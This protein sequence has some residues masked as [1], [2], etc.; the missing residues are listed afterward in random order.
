[1]P[2][3]DT[4]SAP[5]HRVPI[6]EEQAVVHKQTMDGDSVTVQT[7]V[8]ET[9]QWAQETL[10]EEDVSVLR[11]PKDQWI[12][13][14]PEIREEEGVII[15]PVV[16]EVLHVEKRLMLVEELHVTRSKK[17]RSIRIPITLRHTVVEV[18]RTEPDSTAG[19]ES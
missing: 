18:T 16:R 7:R 2:D 4:D 10:L 9:T 6:V 5:S 14:A 11:K 1:M 8:G 13:V 15:I 19:G 12:S 17:E 3:H